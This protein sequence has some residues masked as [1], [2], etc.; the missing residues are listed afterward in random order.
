MLD[1]I[2]HCFQILGLNKSFSLILSVI[3]NEL[4]I[5]D[6][7]VRQL[8]TMLAKAT[9]PRNAKRYLDTY[10]DGLRKRYEVYIEELQKL[11]KHP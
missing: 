5:S 2:L 3:V 11:D 10:G 8:L 6:S 4:L 9:E 7:H 1:Y